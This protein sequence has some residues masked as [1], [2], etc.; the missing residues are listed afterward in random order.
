MNTLDL[1]SILEKYNKQLFESLKNE[2]MQSFRKDMIEDIKKEIYKLFIDNKKDQYTNICGFKRTR[3]RG[4][5]K[6]TVKG[7]V[8]PYH[9]KQIKN[10]SKISILPDELPDENLY[11]KHIFTNEKEDYINIEKRNISKTILS[12]IKIYDYNKK[13]LSVLKKGTKIYNCKIY[14]KNINIIDKYENNG[15]SILKLIEYN[16]IDP[17]MESKKKKKRKNKNKKSGTSNSDLEIE[18]PIF[19]KINKNIKVEFIKDTKGKTYARNPFPDKFLIEN[20]Y[21]CK[22]YTFLH[23]NGIDKIKLFLVNPKNKKDSKIKIIEI[24][25]LEGLML[26][27][28]T[29]ETVNKYFNR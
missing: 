8:C 14:N 10:N 7:F 4:Y 18:K 21:N 13:Y 29:E 24:S 23:D 9:L 19:E 5:C 6:R 27:V 16:I 1:P 15:Y 20:K 2:L 3:Q 11:G 22:C 28:Y 26:E 17:K 12:N 25:D